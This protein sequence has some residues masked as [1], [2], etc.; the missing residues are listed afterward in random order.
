MNIFFTPTISRPTH[1]RRKRR[2]ETEKTA[3]MIRP[4]VLTLFWGFVI[5]ILYM[6][7]R[8]KQKTIQPYTKPYIPPKTILIFSALRRV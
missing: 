8:E 5:T 4:G 3:A 7:K 1:L 2:T 6:N